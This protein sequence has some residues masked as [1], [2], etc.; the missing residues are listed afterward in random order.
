VP[1]SPPTLLLNVGGTFVSSDIE[2]V[3]G[4]GAPAAFDIGN[5]GQPEV[6]IAG[7]NGDQ[8]IL[9]VD[10][11][12]PSVA[13]SPFVSLEVGRDWFCLESFGV[14]DDRLYA[15]GSFCGTEDT[16]G[17]PDGPDRL[18]QLNENLTATGSIETPLDDTTRIL[19]GAGQIFLAGRTFQENPDRDG[20]LSTASASSALDGDAQVLV[21]SDPRSVGDIDGDGQR[22]LFVVGP[23]T[24]PERDDIVW[25]DE[26]PRDVFGPHIIDIDGDGVDDA[27]IT[28]LT[29][30]YEV[31]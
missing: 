27:V 29:Y 26:A 7:L 4:A 2:D 13:S 24:P 9:R 6:I 12:S 31:P 1:Y 28:R 15:S 17:R 14:V 10:G 8:H 30:T 18:F 5:D 19:D 25:L 20:P 23:A 3:V 16:T 22:S 21:E 11:G